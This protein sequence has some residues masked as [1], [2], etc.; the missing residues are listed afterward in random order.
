MTANDE[1]LWKDLAPIPKLKP[2]I[3]DSI[4]N[5]VRYQLKESPNL[6]LICVLIKQLEALKISQV[7]PKP[8]FTGGCGPTSH[9]LTRPQGPVQK[10]MINMIPSSLGLNAGHPMIPQCAGAVEV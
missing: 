5:K 3:S 4:T 8:Q 10:N 9:G 7:K 2:S 6:D 1:D